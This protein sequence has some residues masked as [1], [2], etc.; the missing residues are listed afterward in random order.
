M[1]DH[2]KN[3]I[4]NIISALELALM[5]APNVPEATLSNGCIK[6]AIQELELI[7]SD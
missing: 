1:N 5:T 3:N 4:T 7:I 6:Q 2:V